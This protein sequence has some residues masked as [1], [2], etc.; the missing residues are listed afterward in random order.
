[1]YPLLRLG[2]GWTWV[3]L[4][5]PTVGLPIQTIHAH[6]RFLTSAIARVAPVITAPEFCTAQDDVIIGLPC[7][8]RP[9]RAPA[10]PGVDMSYPRD[11]LS[12]SSH[13]TDPGAR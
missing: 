11:V 2:L 3:D 6:A 13:S 5:G 10:D 12:D 1:M 4:R 8:R 7:A 9:R